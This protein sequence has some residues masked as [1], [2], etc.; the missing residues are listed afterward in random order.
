[1]KADV[2]VDATAKLAGKTILVTGAG[3]FIGSHLTERLLAMGAQVRAL[4]HYNALGSRGWLE[5]VEHKNL[6]VLQGDITDAWSAAQAMQGACHVI[7][8]AALIAIP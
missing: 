2:L 6:N 1:M 3:G 8:L 5:G 4:D 7:H